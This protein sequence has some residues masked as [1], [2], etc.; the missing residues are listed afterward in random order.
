MR[1]TSKA[2]GPPA[3][4]SASSAA[5]PSSAVTTLVQPMR[6]RIPKATWGEGRG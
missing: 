3:A 2:S 1:I 5:S 4:C 6:L